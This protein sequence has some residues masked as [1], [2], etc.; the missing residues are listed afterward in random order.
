MAEPLQKPRAE[1]LSREQWLAAALEVLRQHGVAGVR[2]VPIARLLGV[3]TGSFYWHFK[4]RQDL[5][6]SMLEYWVHTITN[7]VMDEI[8]ENDEVRAVVLTGAGRAFCAGAD[9]ER[10]RNH[11][12]PSGVSPWNSRSSKLS[13]RCENSSRAAPWA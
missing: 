4:D 13:T 7:S 2:I 6:Q 5:L 9:L 1:Q 10:G 11:R 3:T 8:D 12:P